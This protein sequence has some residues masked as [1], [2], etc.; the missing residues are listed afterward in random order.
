[1][2]NHSAP[3]VTVVMPAMNREA[4][5]GEALRSISAQT[6]PPAEVIVVDDASTDATVAVARE[7]GATVIEL[8]VNGGSGPARNRGIEA[9][10]TPW[11]A[12]LDSDDAWLPH[13]LEELLA[14]AGDHALVTA[15]GATPEGRVMGN[16][17][18]TTRVLSPFDVLTGDLVCT[19]GTMVR[20]EAL[21]GA[22]GFRAL[23]RAQDLDMWVRVLERSS[24]IAL[25]RIG[26]TYVLH[27]EQAILDTDLMRSCVDQVVRGARER[28]WLSQR[29]ADRVYVRRRWD[30]ARSAQRA[31]RR[32]EMTH[33]LGWVAR[34]PH[35]WR[36]LGA[37]LL[38]RRR[39][40][41]GA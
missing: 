17:L 18:P 20:R 41:Q 33:H 14:A 21:L 19:S 1:M 23:R 3:Q 38:Q 15:P 29:D 37:M 13:H 36:T 5:I 24:G 4:F 32:G 27:D 22:G 16:A 35:T 12:F 10:S 11:V 2:P 26:F 8:A 25:S 7:H 6:V 9:A 39:A 31:G 28:G 34:R 40:R 30:D